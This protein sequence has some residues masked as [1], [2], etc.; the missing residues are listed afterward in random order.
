MAMSSKFGILDSLPKEKRV[1]AEVVES[2]IG[3]T[4]FVDEYVFKL[5]GDDAGNRLAVFG[6]DAYRN[7]FTERANDIAKPD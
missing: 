2:R 5:Q 4:V 1:S 3:T 6:R 7:G